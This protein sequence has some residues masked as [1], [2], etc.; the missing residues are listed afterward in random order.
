MPTE[1]PD[2]GTSERSPARRV[3]VVLFCLVLTA[4]GLC[5]PV[6][7]ADEYPVELDEDLDL[8]AAGNQT[9][10][11]AANLDAGTEITVR[12]RSSGEN[13]FLQQQQV[14]V[15]E[16]GTFTATFDLRSATVGAEYTTVVIGDDGQ[17]SEPVEGTIHEPGTEVSTVGMAT[18]NR[19][20]AGETVRL[21]VSMPA[22][23]DVELRIGDEAEVGY[24]V[25]VALY[26]R[27]G[28]G[29]VGVRFDTAAAG[30]ADPTVSVTDGGGYEIVQPETPLDSPLDANDYPLTLYEDATDEDPVTLGQLTV[31]D[32]EQSAEASG[33]NGDETQDSGAYTD[34][35]WY[36][37]APGIAG[38]IAIISGLLSLRLYRR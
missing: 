21:N 33:E 12:V 37:A 18:T 13:P 38:I 4:G 3:S 1:R 7:A 22:N 5:P 28:D 11:G 10:T 25:T 24:Q 14:T 34:T 9:V 29:E 16:D 31:T 17:L 2:S 30:T 35:W 15:E 20:T 32:G 19:V 26:D 6:A 23:D 36:E 8:Q 27:D